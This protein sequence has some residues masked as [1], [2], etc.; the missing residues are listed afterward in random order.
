MACST[1]ATRFIREEEIAA[2]P[3]RFCDKIKFGATA[4]TASPTRRCP[5]TKDGSF[6]ALAGR[7]NEQ[8]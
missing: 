7:S 5:T 8:K 2:G 3:H 1:C 4:S 6:C